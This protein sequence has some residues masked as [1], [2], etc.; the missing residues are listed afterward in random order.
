MGDV[1]H[2]QSVEFFEGQFRRQVQDREYGLRGRVRL[3]KLGPGAGGRVRLAKFAFIVEV[4]A[5]DWGRAWMSILL[6]NPKNASTR[7]SMN[8]KISNDFTRSSVRPEALEG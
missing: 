1:T 8:G 4:T 2:R 7:L 3:A 6:I 5:Q